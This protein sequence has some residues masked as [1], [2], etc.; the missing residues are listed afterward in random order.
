M[1]TNVQKVMYNGI[2]YNAVVSS[3]AT[4]AEMVK[5]MNNRMDPRQAFN[6]KNEIPSNYN[7]YQVRAYYMCTVERGFEPTEVPY[8][9]NSFIADADENWQ[10]T[11]YAQARALFINALSEDY[12]RLELVVGDKDDEDC[13]YIVVEEW[14]R[15]KKV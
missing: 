14:A 5:R 2:E 4:K 15:Q 6:L 7:T 3:S 9:S 13:P 11:D 1:N 12:Y 8:A 10:W